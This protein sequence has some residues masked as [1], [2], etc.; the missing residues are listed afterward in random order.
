MFIEWE[1]FQ[2]VFAK[3]HLWNETGSGDQITELMETRT[4]QTQL[5]FHSLKQINSI[6]YVVIYS[7]VSLNS[8]EGA[9]RG[10]EYG[11]AFS[12]HSLS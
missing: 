5:S 2:M 12:Q 7:T 10:S 4:L 8:F 11:I 6:N 1:D 9:E 3:L